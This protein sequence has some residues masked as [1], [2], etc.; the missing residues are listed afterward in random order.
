MVA[1]HAVPIA[2]VQ[3]TLYIILVVTPVLNNIDLTA[4]GPA[5]GAV[6]LSLP[7]TAIFSNIFT[8]GPDRGPS[9]DAGGHLSSDFYS[10]IAE[11]VFGIQPCGGELLGMPLVG[12][13]LSF[14]YNFQAAI[15]D[16]GIFRT[17]SVVLLLIVKPA[18]AIGQTGLME[19]LS[20]INRWL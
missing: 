17:V 9:T 14:G 2:E 6:A 13:G 3:G 5:G 19:P 10:T 1:D 12:K 8:Q 20:G 18:P 4:V 16:I 15:A 7:V 11:G